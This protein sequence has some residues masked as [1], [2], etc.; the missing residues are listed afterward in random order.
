MSTES[1]RPLIARSFLGL[2]IGPGGKPHPD[3]K[4]LPEILGL[5]E[6]AF[7]GD[8]RRR[9]VSRREQQFGPL[10]LDAQDLFLG[11]TAEELSQ[12]SL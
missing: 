7:L 4:H 1:I 3:S 6:A 2:A 5:A 9:D 10:D 12:P 11:R 8:D